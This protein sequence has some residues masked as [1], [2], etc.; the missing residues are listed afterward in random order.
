MGFPC[1]ICG[2]RLSPN[3]HRVLRCRKCSLEAERNVVESINIR[4]KAL[5]MWGVTVPPESQPMKMGGWKV[6]VTK[7]MADQNGCG[8]L[9][10]DGLRYFHRVYRE[11]IIGLVLFQGNPTSL[12]RVRHIP[13]RP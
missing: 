4:L 13:P 3:G 8:L 12:A 9:P 11:H 5:K 10:R 7:V 1:P 6:T 2:E